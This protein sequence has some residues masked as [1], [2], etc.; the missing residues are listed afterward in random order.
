MS[1]KN[2]RGAA[3]WFVMKDRFPFPLF[4]R[5]RGRRQPEI[6]RVEVGS[7]ITKERDRETGRGRESGSLSL[8][9]SLSC[10]VDEKRPSFMVL[11]LKG[12]RTN[13]GM[14]EGSRRELLFM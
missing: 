3:G 9:L 8:S 12:E 1:S 4:I 7:S 11:G 5:T 14:N 2:N 10:D 6:S 13:G